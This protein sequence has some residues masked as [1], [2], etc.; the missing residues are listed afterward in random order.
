MPGVPVKSAAEALYIAAEME[1]RA[2]RLYERAAMVFGSGA[3]AAAI[4]DM[5][6]DERQHLLRFQSMLTGAPP[7]GTE[8]LMLSAYAAGVL[9]EGGLHGAAREGAF[10]SPA[11]LL[12]YASE[13]E[14]LAVDCYTRF[15]QQCN[16]LPEA[17]S[18]FLAVAREESRH[19]AALEKAQAL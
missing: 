11:A 8:A 10:D 16:E 14:R 17:Q 3:I 1:K 18:A 19:L 9:F 2:I 6:A 7:I 5:L 12:R 15:A 13:Q 4:Q